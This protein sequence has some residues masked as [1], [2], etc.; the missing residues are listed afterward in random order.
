[1][2]T[3]EDQL[4]LHEGL[5]LRPYRCTAGKLTIGV[6][7]NLD[8]VGIRAAETTKLGLTKASVV[9]NGVSR[10]QA[11]TLLENDIEAAKAGLDRFAAWWRVLDPIRRRVLIDMCFNLGE[12]RLASFVNTLAAVR[13]RDWSAAAAGMR[14]SLW[15]RQVGDRGERLAVMMQTGADYA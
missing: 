5:R 6:G 7:R 4:V 14:N 10:A 13:R 3:I 15:Y 8:D 9:A 2:P 1:M 12:A 11:F